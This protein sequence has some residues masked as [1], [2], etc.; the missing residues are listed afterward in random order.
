VIQFSDYVQAIHDD[1]RRSFE[2]SVRE[3]AIVSSAR[4]NGGKARWFAPW[5]M[6]RARRS[7]ASA[8]PA[9]SP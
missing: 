3:A 8:G 9:P 4:R 5:R 7:S 6:S 2:A 1:R